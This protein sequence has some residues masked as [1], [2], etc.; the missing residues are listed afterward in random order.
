MLREDKVGEGPDRRPWQTLTIKLPEDVALRV[1]EA[2]AL[3]KGFGLAK[4]EVEAWEAIAVEFSTNH[5]IGALRAMRGASPYKVNSIQTLID[6]GFRC[7][8]CCTSRDLTIHHIL[9]RGNFVDRPDDIHQPENLA[10]LCL[11]D[12]EKVQSR[13]RDYVLELQELRRKACR[14]VATYGYR[15]TKKHM[16]GEGFRWT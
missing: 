4:N 8:L 11:A 15:L 1:H 7:L 13:W 12:H 5:F 9:P 14:E 16:R 3:A 6:T 10:P 2:L